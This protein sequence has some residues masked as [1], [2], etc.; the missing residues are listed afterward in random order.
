[1]K[2]A[3]LPG[4]PY[5]I[6][7]MNLDL[8]LP[9]QP[10]PDHPGWVL[11]SPTHLALDAAT[12][13]V[14]SYPPQDRLLTIACLPGHC[15]KYPRIVAS[16]FRTPEGLLYFAELVVGADKYETLG[17]VPSREDPR[18][19][20]RVRARDLLNRPDLDHVPLRW[21]CPTQQTY[22]LR[23]LDPVKVLGHAEAAVARQVTASRPS[24]GV[25]RLS[26]SAVLG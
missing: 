22:D 20:Y 1:M 9:K 19:R 8:D 15:G 14:R 3:K 7:Q 24:D 17:G 2:R 13:H 21:Q 10:D 26:V 11:G 12:D 25:S 4:E 16:V 6:V 23:P 5:A 18:R